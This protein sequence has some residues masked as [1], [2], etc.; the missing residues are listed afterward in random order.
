MEILK[1]RE[2]SD[3]PA[4]IQKSTGETRE[5]AGFQ[6]RRALATHQGCFTTAHISLCA[7]TPTKQHITA[8]LVGIILVFLRRWPKKRIHRE[9]LQFPF[10][11]VAGKHMNSLAG[12][13]PMLLPVPYH[14]NS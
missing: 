13:S 7:V 3:L 11:H 5:N 12:Y 9:L 2:L 4:V 6:Q 8:S 14:P 10:V 1:H